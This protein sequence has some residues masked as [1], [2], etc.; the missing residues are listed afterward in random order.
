MSPRLP[1]LVGVRVKYE[2][3]FYSTCLVLVRG[4]ANCGFYGSENRI[5][6]IFAKKKIGGYKSM[7]R[8]D[9]TLL[10]NNA[11]IHWQWIE[12]TEWT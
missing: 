1:R 2:S 10:V 5:I 9:S 8:L 7:L 4:R 6:L 12:W 3:A 11:A